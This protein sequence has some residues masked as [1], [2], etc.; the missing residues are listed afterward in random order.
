MLQMPLGQAGAPVPGPPLM[1]HGH[2]PPPPPAVQPAPPPMDHHYTIMSPTMQGPAQLAP[3]PRMGPSPPLP[4]VGTPGMPGSPSGH[5]RHRG[6]I[7]SNGQ[8]PPALQ[9]QGQGQGAGPGPGQNQD[10][11]QKEGK[12]RKIAAAPIPHNRPWPPNGGS[13]LRLSSYDPKGSIKDYKASEPPPRSGP[14]TIR[15]WSV[16]NV[17]KSRNRNKKEGSAEDNRESPK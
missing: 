12:Y 8:G 14:T 9:L 1:I 7:S 6:S 17:N 15:G 5:S 10:R 16:N 3:M 4:P 13:E 11:N 2:P